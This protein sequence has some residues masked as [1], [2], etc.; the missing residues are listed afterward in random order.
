MFVLNLAPCFSGMCSSSSAT[1]ACQAIR[2]LH[3][4][5]LAIT[6]RALRVRTSE[7]SSYLRFEFHSFGAFYMTKFQDVHAVM[8]RR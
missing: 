2:E 7:S 6:F 3:G 4:T 8:S 1:A 5:Q